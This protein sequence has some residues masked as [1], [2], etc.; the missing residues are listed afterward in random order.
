VKTLNLN[1]VQS[2]PRRVAV[3]VF[4]GVHLGHR[5]VIKGSDT[6]VTFDPH[7]LTVIHPE[8]A[9]HLITPFKRKQELIAELGVDE[10]VV[11]PFNKEFAQL[12]ATDFIQEILVKKL[13]AT[14]VSVGKNFRFGLRAEGD[15]ELLKQAGSFDVNVAPL[16][17]ADGETISSTHIR[18]LIAAG[19]VASASHFLG[20]PFELAGEVVHGYKRG[21]ELGFPTANIVP[22]DQYLCPGHGVYA[23]MVNA[24]QPAA[25]N[26]GV[27][28]TFESGR[29]LLVEAYLLDYNGDLYGKRL[30]IRFLKRL[31]GEKAFEKVEDLVAQMK[32]DV[33][34]TRTICSSSDTFVSDES[35][36]R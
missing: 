36:V 11:V 29:A 9:P 30:Q 24:G 22:H 6:V 19:D 26:I 8:V 10:L 32:V 12:S 14:R 21:R 4:D 25:V 18:G 27:S 20:R 33:E 31:R 13:T 35:Y 15:T 3:G 34:D 17:E 28:P 23:C 2:R 1:E 7:P 5:N 16:V